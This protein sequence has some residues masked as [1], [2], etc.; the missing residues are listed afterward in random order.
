VFLLDA[1]DIMTNKTSLIQIV[2]KKLCIFSLFYTLLFA[3]GCTPKSKN[4]SILPFSLDEVKSVQVT[5]LFSGPWAWRKKEVTKQKD[6]E[7]IYMCFD[8]LE[9]TEAD[10]PLGIVGGGANN[11][12]FILNDGSLFHIYYHNCGIVRIYGYSENTDEAQE[13]QNN[14]LSDYQCYGTETDIWSLLNEMKD[15]EYTPLYP[16]LQQ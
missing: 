6:I 13:I 8:D 11:I 15:Y 3:A 12:D 7:K 2:I 1:V 14:E 5:D 9:E 4:S 16:E 10:I